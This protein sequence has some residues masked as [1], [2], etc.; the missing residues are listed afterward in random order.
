MPHT[1]TE[2]IHALVISA[3]ISRAKPHQVL[4]LW[5]DSG[6]SRWMSHSM[7]E[8]SENPRLKV[9]REDVSQVW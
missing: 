1:C 8:R 3:C 5:T 4:T 9:S 2:P 6:L 7:L